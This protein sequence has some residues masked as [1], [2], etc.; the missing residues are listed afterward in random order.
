VSTDGHTHARTDA[1]RFYYL[2][3]AICYSYGADNKHGEQLAAKYKVVMCMQHSSYVISNFEFLMLTIAFYNNNDICL[4][5]FP[6]TLFIYSRFM[7]QFSLIWIPC[8]LTK[9]FSVSM[10]MSRPAVEAAI[11][12]APFFSF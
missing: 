11:H 12:A 6:L 8:V 5:G 10:F 9:V 7:R 3:H 2:S 4:S 1:K